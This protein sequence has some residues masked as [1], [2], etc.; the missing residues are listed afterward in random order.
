MTRYYLDAR[1]QKR[2]SRDDYDEMTR[3]VARSVASDRDVDRIFFKGLVQKLRERD[4]DAF[5]NLV[6]AATE[7]DEAPVGWFEEEFDVEDAETVE[8][9]VR[10]L[11]PAVP[12]V[13]FEEDGSPVFVR[14]DDGQ[15]YFSVSEESRHW[16]S[17]SLG[18]VEG[19][20]H[21]V[22]MDD[23]E[24]TGEEGITEGVLK[25]LMEETPDADEGEG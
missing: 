6:D 8:D 23:V 22:S 2:E 12:R 13:A 3:E 17:E 16:L 7:G 1:K 18:G 4:E 21:E 9:V 14:Y 10:L 11:S 20:I 5:L 24:G 19:R 15:V 25:A